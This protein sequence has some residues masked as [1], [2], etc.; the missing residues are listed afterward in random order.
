MSKTRAPIK[1]VIVIIGEN[2][3]F[4]HVFATYKPQHGEKVDNL[5]SK[6]IIT[7]GGKPGLNFE[8]ARQYSAED[9]HAA[10]YQV[11]PMGKSA[12]PTLPTP[13]AGGPTA[14]YIPSLAIAK[15]VEN[16]LPND[17]HYSCLMT[18]GTG[19]KGGTPDTRISNVNSLPAGPF[20]L[21]PGVPCDAYAASPVHRLYQ[22]WQELD[23]NVN[24]PT[25]WNPSGCR[26]DL[27]PFV[28]PSVGAGA[29]GLPRPKPFTDAIT[30]EGGMAMGFYNVLQGDAPYLRE[31]ADNYAMSDNFHQAVM[32]GTGTNHG[33]IGTGDTIWFSDGGGQA[34]TPPHHQLVAAGTVNAGVVDEVENPTA[35]PD[36]NNWYT[37]DGY[38]GGSGRSASFGGG[39]YSN[40][41]DLRA[42]GVSAVRESTCILCRTMS[43]RSARMDTSI[44]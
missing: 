25:R 17:T 1:R 22:M 12:Y 43:T 13:L 38:G 34:A 15:F 20:Q 2:R 23:C 19:L 14:P 21:T 28:E 11:S 44:C 3:T 9:T 33:A 16:G 31:L 36:T 42:P 4:D 26:N 35:A 41:S 8:L 24:Y 7:E 30:G 39:T 6:R 32:G 40:C 18:G 29:D 10:G 37:E 27:F 5:L